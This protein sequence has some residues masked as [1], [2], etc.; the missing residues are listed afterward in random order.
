MEWG[1]DTVVFIDD[2]VSWK[3]QDLVTLLQTEGDV[4]SGTYRYKVEAEQYMGNIRTGPDHRPLVR[5]DG[6]MA[7]FRVPAGFLKVTKR[8][9]ERFMEA[10]PELNVEKDGFRSPDLFNH[11]A[12][13]GTWFG[14]DMAFSLRWIQAGGK[15]WLVPDLDLDHNGKDKVYKGNFHNF[16]RRQPG[17]SLA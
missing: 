13:R 6:A 4:V 14:E 9:W 16:L 5:E 10:Y 8:A 7:A 3:P 15:I 1:A 2:D 12:I 17:G 11:G